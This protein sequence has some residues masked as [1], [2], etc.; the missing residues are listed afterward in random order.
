MSVQSQLVSFIRKQSGIQWNTGLLFENMYFY[1]TYSLKTKILS[2]Q[3]TG[4]FLKITIFDY[5]REKTIC[6]NHKNLVP[7][8]HK[9]SPIRKN[10]LPQ[11]FRATRYFVSMLP[12]TGHS[13]VIGRTY[14]NYTLHWGPV[15]VQF[16]QVT[17][18]WNSNIR[19]DKN[20]MVTNDIEMG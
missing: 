2:M 1:C 17:W 16:W 12:S 7:R 8:K 20:I 19:L 9:K 5:Q 15:R 11:K 6:P 10:K 14:Y 13:L 3:G 4:Y 18:L